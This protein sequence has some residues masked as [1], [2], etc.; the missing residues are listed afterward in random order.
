MFWKGRLV[1]SLDCVFTGAVPA[2]W[3]GACRSDDTTSLHENTK[4][5]F[6]LTRGRGGCKGRSQDMIPQ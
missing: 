5:M 2:Y 6:N 3:G 4:F 1:K